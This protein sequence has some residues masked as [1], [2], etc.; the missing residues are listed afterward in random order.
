MN[1][2]RFSHTLTQLRKKTLLGQK[3]TN[4]GALVPDA[5]KI[6]AK[7]E[8]FERANEEICGQMFKNK[9]YCSLKDFIDFREKLKTALRHYE[10]H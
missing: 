3:Q 9:Q 6:S 10:F 4:K 2:E 8:D 7:E 1:K 5:R